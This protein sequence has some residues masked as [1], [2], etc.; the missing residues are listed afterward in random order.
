MLFLSMLID[1]CFFEYMQLKLV[2]GF[3]L[4]VVLIAQKFKFGGCDQKESVIYGVLPI[5]ARFL[6]G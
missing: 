1:V 4:V 3:Y 2:T 5:F 6:R